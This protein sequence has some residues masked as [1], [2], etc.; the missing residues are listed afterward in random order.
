M[1]R[2]ELISTIADETG[3]SKKKLREIERIYWEKIYS[4]EDP[5]YTYG[6]VFKWIEKKSR[7]GKEFKSGGKVLIPPK[8][9]LNFKPKEKLRRVKD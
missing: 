9:S 7:I 4:E 8:R 5:V 6:G 3:V 1:R 2:E